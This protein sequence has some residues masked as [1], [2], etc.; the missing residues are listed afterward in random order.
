MAF[1]SSF[2]VELEFGNVGFFGKR[3]TRVPG[4][5]TFGA[6]TRINSKF[7]PHVAS[8]PG[9]EPGPHWLEVSAQ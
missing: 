7:D 1:S 6:G 8:T 3:K 9:I 4:G 2:L 5:K